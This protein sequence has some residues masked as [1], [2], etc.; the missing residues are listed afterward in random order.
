[1]EHR[2]TQH[3][4]LKRNH[5]NCMPRY[6]VGYD[7]E[8][9]ETQDP[10]SNR[11]FSHRWRLATAV[12][13]RLRGSGISDIKNARFTDPAEFWAWLVGLTGSNYTTW[14][15]SH[16]ALFD[17]VVSGLDQKFER[18]ELVIE[19][20][21][22]KRQR[23]DNQDDNV[24]CHSLCVI[25]SPPT[26][27]ACK[28]GL[29]QGRIVLIDTLNW[30]PVPLSDLGDSIGMPKLQ[31]PAQ[32]ASD[33]KW[34]EYC[35][36]DSEIVFHTFTQLINWVQSNDLGIFRYTAASQAMSGF[37]HR[38]MRQNIY[39]HA[40]EGVRHIE[41]LGLFGGRTDV[42]RI[43]TIDRVVHQVDVSGLF[44]SVMRDRYYPIVLDRS[45]IRD[46]Y[47]ELFPSL[48]W[49]N[50]I[51][52]V[53]LTT[54][55]P[56]FPQRRGN[57]VCYPIGTFK[58][59]LCGP[60]LQYAIKKHYVHAIR[61]WAEYRTEQIFT[62]W[63]DALWSMRQEYR[64]TGNRLYEQFVKYL[65]NSLYGK[66][67]QRAPK[68]VNLKGFTGFLPWSTWIDNAPGT[69][70]PTM[71]RSFGWQ[72]QY[73]TGREEIDG[74]F[75]A[76]ASFVTSHARMR[77]NALR[78][79]A[80]KANVYYQGVDG[81]IVT[82]DGLTRLNAAGE[83][84]ENELGKLRLEMTTD[85]GDILGCS[86]YRLGNKVIVAGRSKR[87]TPDDLDR[88]M[89]RKFYATQYLF[90]GKAISTVSAE[91]VEW[92]RTHSYNKGVVMSGGWIEPLTLNEGDCNVK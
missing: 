9:I 51:A 67:G 43:G 30:F 11:K 3:R 39:P 28:C 63:V 72:A 56:I 54:M 92:H 4:L 58:T 5:A 29:T 31:M 84:Q 55:D 25:E 76:I 60:E 85:N 10:K 20:P 48:E 23:E 89:Q 40:N 66:F 62:E 44:P 15:V 87:F 64:R 42:F 8:T 6:I 36:R 14:V 24:H 78:N 12:Y 7:V 88:G 61:S 73:M 77:M 57:A 2:Q 33:D 32:S 68:W 46:D 18:G 86:D 91:D 83:V 13:G 49:Q 34:F 19:W 81:L 22:S 71:F 16:N 50:A 47:L 59:V 69:K 38:F 65:A 26:I 80:G 41:R 1:M 45:E 75:I 37:R 53:E 52:E 70:Q 90:S 27:I 74:T 21:R 17:F 82:T 35:Q 79:I